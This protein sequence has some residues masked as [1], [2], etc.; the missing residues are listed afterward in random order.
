M[1]QEHTP[2]LHLLMHEFCIKDSF[3]TCFTYKS[4]MKISELAFSFYF[5]F[6]FI[7]KKDVLFLLLS[8]EPNFIFFFSFSFHTYIPLCSK[9]GFSPSGSPILTTGAAEGIVDATAQCSS[10]VFQQCGTQRSP[11]FEGVLTYTKQLQQEINHDF[12]SFR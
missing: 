5:S 2:K 11:S 4:M 10:P 6:L 8:E 1:K 7:R 12:S 9:P 3:D